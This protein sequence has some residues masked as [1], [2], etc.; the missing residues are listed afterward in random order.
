MHHLLN[1]LV[2][3]Q[4]A[5]EALLPPRDM[6]AW[7]GLVPETKVLGEGAVLHNVRA[8]QVLEQTF[9]LPDHLK[10]TA[11]PVMV[12]GV[13][14]EVTR[15]VVDPLG[16]ERDLY[17]GGTGVPFVGPV[18]VNRG[19]LIERH[20]RKFLGACL[21]RVRQLRRVFA[22]NCMKHGSLLHLAQSVKDL[23]VPDRYLGKQ[24]GKYRVI[25]LLGGG[26]FAWVYEAID[27]DLEIPVAL[28]ILRPEFAGQADAE[29]RFR[30]EAATAARLR[31]PNIVTV[32]DVGQIDGA[33]FVAMDLLPVSLGRRLELVGPLPESEVVR[34]G[35]DVA[36]ALATAHAGGV[37]H[38]DIKPDNILIGPHGEFVVADFGLARALSADPG[39][40]A[41]QVMGTPHYFS[42]EQARG[43]ELDGRSDLYSLGVTLFRAAT[44]RLPFEGE[45]WYAVARQHIEAA[46]PLAREYTPSLTPEFEAVVD[47]LLRKDATGRYA[48]ALQ[49]ADALAGLPSSPTPRSTA[50]A[51]TGA[52][53]TVQVSATQPS[54]APPATR[55]RTRTMA[56]MGLLATGVVALA[57]WQWP[58]IRAVLPT[59]VPAPQS[60]VVEPP[61]AP[62]GDTIPVAST[63][64]DSA[65]DSAALP[66]PR[67]LEPETSTVGDTVRRQAQ[68]AVRTKLLLRAPDDAMLYVDDLLVG[69]GSATI[70]RPGAARLALRAVIADAPV[71][72][73]AAKRD[74]IV[75]L[76][77]GE[78]ERTVVLNVKSCLTVRFSVTPDDARVRFESLDGGAS[79]DVS[80]DATMVM[81][82]EGR[83]EVR[84][85]APRCSPYMGD[86]LIVRRGAASESLYRPIRMDCK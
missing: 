40:S 85:S 54:L 69:H 62:R 66:P 78:K 33:S 15:Q 64:R 29:A 51:R 30:R 60:A 58:T 45:E 6:M 71:S 12:L 1:F 39:L 81:L 84:A 5:R 20:R 65:A 35:L 25:K 9:A 31:H 8:L 49:L 27:R 19:C 22:R 80:A 44:G 3:T 83:Y 24:I 67:A 79:V 43:A 46:P 56:L 70:T 86:T 63:A 38:R 11:T 2:R 75:R 32:R 36:A 55:V 23:T 72:C 14:T 77:V 16:E 73:A 61:P 13:G 18:L 10:E 28:K 68:A 53:E 42:P 57:L 34:V 59:S 82:P 17:A 48:T 26:S 50:T 41:Q 4:I 21:R 7:S 47:R 76:N 74:S 52:S 37:V